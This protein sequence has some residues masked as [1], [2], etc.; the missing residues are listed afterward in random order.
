M[1]CTD[2]Q[3]QITW[4]TA[5]GMQIKIQ[6]V[7]LKI[8]PS[9]H[10]EIRNEAMKIVRCGNRSSFQNVVFSSLESRTIGEVHKSVILSLVHLRQNPLHSTSKQK[11]KAIP[12]IGLGGL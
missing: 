9:I 2:V 10:L 11:G 6:M 7:L 4:E 3:Q 1:L 12:V 5:G 8:Y